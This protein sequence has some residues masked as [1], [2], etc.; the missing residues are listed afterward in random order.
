MGKLA[1]TSQLDG[2]PPT[3][4]TKAGNLERI[5]QDPRQPGYLRSQYDH[6]RRAEWDPMENLTM[7]RDEEHMARLVLQGHRRQYQHAK[8]ASSKRAMVNN[9]LD[10][11][12]AYK[13]KIY[14][15]K[16]ALE[17]VEPA[18]DNQVLWL[19]QFLNRKL[20]KLEREP[21]RRSWWKLFMLMDVDKQ[22]RL[23]RKTRGLGAQRPIALP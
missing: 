12:A 3:P 14:K 8:V 4:P 19:S 16:I 20:A 11:A 5:Q 15:E 23:E 7:A 2:T 9:R 1:N 10:E 21:A 6:G 22:A 13:A 18:D 17:S